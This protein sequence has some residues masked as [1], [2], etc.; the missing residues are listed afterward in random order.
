MLTAVSQN[1]PAYPSQE[2]H[3][4]SC[5]RNSFLPSLLS[6]VVSSTENIV[7]REKNV[8]INSGNVNNTPQQ[9]PDAAS[10]EKIRIAT[11]CLMDIVALLRLKGADKYNEPL[12]GLLKKWFL[13]GRFNS[14][15]LDYL[16]DFKFK[17]APGSSKSE[18]NALRSR[19]DNILASCEKEV[20]SVRSHDNYY[21]RLFDSFFASEI[22]NSPSKEML[23]AAK[24]I[25]LAI[26]ENFNSRH[27]ENERNWLCHELK[28]DL[29][30][31][32][33][34]WRADISE[35]SDFFKNSTPEN[36]IKMLHSPHKLAHALT[37]H[38]AVKYIALSP[39][40]YP[41]RSQ[42]SPIYTYVIKPQ[43]KT[44]LAGDEMPVSKLVGILLKHQHR[45]NTFTT[46][47]A[48]IRPLDTIKPLTA[49]LTLHNKQA[50]SHGSPVATG[51]SGSA[52]ILNYFFHELAE[53]S[54]T[55]DMEQA[56]LLSAAELTYSGGHSISE[57]YTSFNLAENRDF[58]PL[59]YFSLLHQ[60]VA[61]KAADYAWEE[62]LK[63]AIEINTPA[64]DVSHS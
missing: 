12:M 18:I 49:E 40:C 33:P 47:G 20:D 9:T 17:G 63:R 3:S 51:M 4:L 21:G 61:R 8:P 11:E 14:A 57:A 44:L 22:I 41:I 27:A 34:A 38:L 16:K 30:A 58:Q 62:V 31:D 10:S 48:G 35:V 5:S 7:I 26:I 24:T 52:N 50:L 53:D 32:P 36:F 42:A 43:K 25:N 60:P 6:K 28:E 55:F 29:I 45:D 19:I 64:A 23:D 1:H 59:D 56:K 46:A 37:I 54:D 39:G 2:Q 13:S 15:S